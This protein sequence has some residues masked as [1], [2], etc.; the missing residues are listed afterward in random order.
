MTQEEIKKQIILFDQEINKIRDELT[1]GEIVSKERYILL[2]TKLTLISEK[3]DRL[4]NRIE[5]KRKKHQVYLKF[6]PYISLIAG[7]IIAYLFSNAFTIILVGII[8][9][10]IKLKV[11]FKI[12][13]NRNDLYKIMGDIT[14]M[15]PKLA[16]TFGIINQRIEKKN[17]YDYGNIMQINAYL[18]MLIDNSISLENVSEEI[19]NEIILILKQD[20]NTNTNDLEELLDLARQKINQESLKKELKLN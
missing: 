15:R 11:D 2:L 14:K 6:S 7:I 19:K 16:N 5:N 12:E 8:Y 3:E 9:L 4:I 20:L 18:I 1:S 10:T 13:N 17:S